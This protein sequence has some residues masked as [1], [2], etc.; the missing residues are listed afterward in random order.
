MI[1]AI[2]DL[3]SNTF[4]LLIAEYV[5]NKFVT[6]YRER[7]FTRLSDGGIEK[8]SE[9]AIEKGH[10][11]LAAFRKT[12]DNY[13]LQKICIIGT[14]A[15][16]T[17]T[18]ANDFIIP[19]EEFIGHPITIIDGDKEAE[20]I[21]K[22][23]KLLSPMIERSLIVDI[24]GG[25]TEFIIVE[26]GQKV[27]AQ[28]YKLGVGVLHSLFHKSEPISKDEILAAKA[29]IKRTIALLLEEVNK[30]PIVSLLG[31]SGSFEIFESMT[32]KATFEREVN[33]IDID[34]AKTIIEKI[35]S[36]NLEQRQSIEGLPPDRTKLIVVGM[37]LV[38]VI[39]D[40]VKPQNLYVT[41]YA[42]KEGLLSEM[43]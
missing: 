24:G 23:V 27:W 11:C 36:A 8:L 29:H 34:D 30:R 25:S 32:G 17:A 20:L 33:Q 2:I 37:I 16:R 43:M 31:A 12:M 3:G 26:G 19:A 40:E 13:H 14:A 41:P 38:D 9:A 10:A 42:L 28:S 39:L 5:D 35:T 7:V 1:Y 21:F 4:H 6:I 18:N 22:G 15:L